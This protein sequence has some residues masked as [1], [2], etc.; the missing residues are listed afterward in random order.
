MVDGCADGLGVG[1]V[2]RGVVVQRRR[3]GLLNFGDVV[4]AELVELVGCD[5]RHHVW[6]EKVENFGGQFARDTHAL[7]ALGVFDGDG[8]VHN[9]P[10]QHDCLASEVF[11]HFGCDS[12]A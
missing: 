11:C 2:A 12:I 10:I 5:T 8:H 3:N 9:Y 1:V 7:C 6:G 4:V